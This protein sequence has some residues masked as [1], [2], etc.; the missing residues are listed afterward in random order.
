MHVKADAA[1]IHVICALRESSAKRQNASIFDRLL[2]TANHLALLAHLTIDT[3]CA[4]E[5]E[6]EKVEE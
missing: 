3:R 5:E 4:S 2:P 1:R 6:T